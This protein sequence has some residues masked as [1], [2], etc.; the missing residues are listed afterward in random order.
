MTFGMAK[1]LTG[2]R[3]IIV[4]SNLLAILLFTTRI[5]QDL[6]VNIMTSKS[7]KSYS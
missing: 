2:V 1:V 3:K 5:A 4:E 7:T 6:T